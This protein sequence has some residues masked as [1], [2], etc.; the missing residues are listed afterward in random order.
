MA[1][2]NLDK[3]FQKYFMYVLLVDKEEIGSNG[4]TGMESKLFE[5]FLLNL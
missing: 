5:N 4:A 1:L 3:R 2:L